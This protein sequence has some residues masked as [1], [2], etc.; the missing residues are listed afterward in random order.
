[1][2]SQQAFGRSGHLSS[3]ILLGAAAFSDVTQAEADAALE[4]ALSFGVNHVDVAASYGEAEL[5]IGNWISRHGK[6]FF[7]A[8][9]TGERTVNKAREEIHRSLERL[10]VTQVDLLQLHNL[11]DPQEWETA[12]GPGGALEAAIE[13]REQGLIRFIGITGHGLRAASMHRPGT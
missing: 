12:L 7:L 10:Q 8:T 4:L 6:P 2:I 9:K 1:M 13:A 5:R 3:R 11:V